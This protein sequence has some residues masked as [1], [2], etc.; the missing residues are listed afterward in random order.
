MPTLEDIK[1]QAYKARGDKGGIVVQGRTLQYEVR[2]WSD[3]HKCIARDA[4]AGVSIHLKGNTSKNHTK[5]HALKLN[6]YN[7]GLFKPVKVPS[8]STDDQ[9]IDMP[10]SKHGF[11]SLV[12][13]KLKVF[14]TAHESEISCK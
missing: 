11:T 10:F 3:V 2:S 6:L 13:H 7:H 5:E 4:K 8:E 14:S 9:S 1:Q 12:S